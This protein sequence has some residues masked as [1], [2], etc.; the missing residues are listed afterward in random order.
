MTNNIGTPPPG[1]QT[2]ARNSERRALVTVLLV[3]GVLVALVAF[4]NVVSGWNLVFDDA[5]IS[6]RYAHNLARGDGLVW[7]VGE[8][9]TEGYTNLLLVIALVPPLMFEMDPLLIVRFLSVIALVAMSY[10]LFRFARRERKCGVA[11][12][13]AVAAIPLIFPA[14]TSIALIGLETTIYAFALLVTFIAALRFLKTNG[15]RAAALLALL[16]FATSLLR[17]EV[18]LLLLAVAAIWIARAIRS[19]PSWR[20]AAVGIAVLLLLLSPYLVWKLYYFGDILPNPFYVKAAGNTASASGAL[21]VQAFIAVGFALITLVIFALARKPGTT[22]PDRDGTVVDT[23]DARSLG[24]VFLILYLGFF[25]RTDTL[26]DIDGRFLYPLI[27][28]LVLLAVPMVDRATAY[29]TDTE[30]NVFV[31]GVAV[32]A[33]LVL[34][35]GLPVADLFRMLSPASYTG[36]VERMQAQQAGATPMR[37]AVSLAGM[38][39]IEGIRIAYG[40]AGV[41]PFVTDAK[42]LDPVGL[43]DS[44][45]ARSRDQASLVDYFFSQKPD[46][47]ILPAD[48]DGSWITYGHGQ[49]GDYAAWSGDARWDDF[50]YVGT[51]RRADAPYDLHFLVRSGADVAPSLTEYLRWNVVDGWYPTMPH[52]LGTSSGA[53]GQTWIPGP[54]FVS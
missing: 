16:V 48:R 17:P 11:S 45:I 25:W 47:V 26:M 35:S 29:A 51:A 44:F 10:V 18:G 21:S 49:L 31:S 3:S 4:D 1:Q 37:L 54:A 38:P 12:A 15:V 13:T 40:D 32:A 46:L 20:P 41:I 52:D 27:P 24:F 33:F 5:Y 50:T 53:Q 23:R 19:R 43:N 9:P 22:L 2:Q 8:A 6:F 36:V 30:V 42:W 39:G 14:S 7:N 34:S 28:I